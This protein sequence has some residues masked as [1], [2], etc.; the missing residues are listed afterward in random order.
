MTAGLWS[1]RVD[2]EVLDDPAEVYLRQCAAHAMEDGQP[3]VR[4]FRES[5]AD[6]GKISGARSSK[7]SAEEAYL[8]HEGAQ[9]TGRAATVGTYGL[10]IDQIRAAGDQTG[11]P[12]RAVDD[13]RRRG[14]EG[15]PGHTY[16][17]QRHLGDR[18]SNPDKR[19]L[20]AALYLRA[21]HNGRLWPTP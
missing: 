1:L 19:A 5:T 20:R 16:L 15:P 8:H 18:P 6:G 10:T 3:S 12:V 17:D 2:E 9:T 14:E 4:M 11:L 7:T 13:S 21:M